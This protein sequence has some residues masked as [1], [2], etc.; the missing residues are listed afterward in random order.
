MHTIVN[1]ILRSNNIH[2][3]SRFLKFR[4]ESHPDYPALSSIQETLEE[5]GINAYACIGTIEELEK[6]NSP[7]L[8]HLNMGDGELT[9]F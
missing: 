8:A 6:E 9:F 1:Q 2:V 7:F 4:L 5:L 3:S